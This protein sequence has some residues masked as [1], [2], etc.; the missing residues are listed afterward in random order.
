MRNFTWKSWWPCSRKR[1][2]QL[3]QYQT[4]AIWSNQKKAG[5]GF[6]WNGPEMF[7]QNSIKSRS[8]SCMGM[9]SSPGRSGLKGSSLTR[10]LTVGASMRVLAGAP[11]CGMVEFPIAN[12]ALFID[13]TILSHLPPWC[14]ARGMMD[15]LLYYL[16]GAVLFISFLML[17]FDSM[18]GSPRMQA[19]H[20]RSMTTA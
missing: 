4:S 18:S 2:S 20:M 1:Q 12:R 16:M 10:A 3:S 17:L 8:T 15:G 11:Y 19:N 6:P 5:N 13:C 9:S 14:G 7:P